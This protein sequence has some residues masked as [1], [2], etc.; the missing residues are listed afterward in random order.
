MVKVKD[1]TTAKANYAGSSSEA[2][3]RWKQEIP[4]A[5]WKA[6]SLSAGA[7]DL[8]RVKTIEALDA[9]RREKG[10]EAVSDAEWRS[11]TLSKGGSTMASAMNQSADKW[12]AKTQPYL[13]AMKSVDLPAKTADPMQNIDNR[14]KPVVQALVD[15]KKQI[16]G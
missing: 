5:E 8:H 16:K 10:I 11:R 2:V 14:Q 1:T 13:D 6:A 4:K 3:R 15:T 7:V 9:G 12:A